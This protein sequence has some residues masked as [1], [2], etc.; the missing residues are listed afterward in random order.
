VCY[1]VCE[2][3]LCEALVA[4]SAFVFVVWRFM[5]Q[6]NPVSGYRVQKLVMTHGYFAGIPEAERPPLTPPADLAQVDAAFAFES[7]TLGINDLRILIANDIFRMH[8]QD[9][10]ERESQRG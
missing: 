6:E 4:T 7:E 2:A 8:E 3:F 5:V 9:M 1:F 10:R